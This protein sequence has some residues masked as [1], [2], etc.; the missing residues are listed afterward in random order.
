MNTSEKNAREN[1]REAVQSARDVWGKGWEHLSAHQQNDAKAGELL[2][3]IE[4]MPF[5]VIVEQFGESA[6][7]GILVV[8]QMLS[9]TQEVTP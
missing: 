1:G 4:S 8:K 9:A 7:P 6:V 5:D 3:T 2:L